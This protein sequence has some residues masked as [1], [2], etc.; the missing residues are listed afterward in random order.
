[1]SLPGKGWGQA[2]LGEW[3]WRPPAAADITLLVP[4]SEFSK[5]P[6]LMPKTPSQKNRRKKRRVSYTQDE[7][8]DP[9]R[10]RWE[11]GQL[12]RWG[13]EAW[14]P[15]GDFELKVFTGSE[16]RP[17]R[18]VAGALWALLRGE[19]PAGRRSMTQDHGA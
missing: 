19:M 15:P 13:L 16:Q 6:E 1:M 5:E 3:G 7:N 18:V 9:V 10:K 11:E 8:R 17:A 12:G 2:G 4:N 14:C